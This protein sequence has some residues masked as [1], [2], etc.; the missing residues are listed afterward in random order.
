M[1]EPVIVAATF[2]IILLLA[3]FL[4]GPELVRR[5]LRGYSGR[6]NLYVLVT[7]N[8]QTVAYKNPQ[9]LLGE[10]DTPLNAVP[11]EIFHSNQFDDYY[12]VCWFDCRALFR[13]GHSFHRTSDNARNCDSTAIDGHLIG[14]ILE[15]R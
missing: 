2:L 4:G 7:I 6:K 8:G 5:L 9:S 11:N 12:N 10:E 15:E 3:F 13:C 14:R 1:T